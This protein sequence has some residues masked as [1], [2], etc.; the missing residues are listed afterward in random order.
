M[1]IPPN[2]IFDEGGLQVAEFKS[3]RRLKPPSPLAAVVHDE[4]YTGDAC[5][6]KVQDP[7]CVK[8]RPRALADLLELRVPTLQRSSFV[9]GS[10]KSFCCH[11]TSRYVHR[12]LTG[13]T[14]SKT[15]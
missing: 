2:E 10:G 3:P 5:A 9:L 14:C 12:T 4:G 8:H 11:F 7:I 6:Y 13:E 1:P 15:C